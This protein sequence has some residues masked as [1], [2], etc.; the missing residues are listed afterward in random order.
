MVEDDSQAGLDHVDGH[1]APVEV[2]SPYANHATVDSHYYSQI[3]MV[4]TI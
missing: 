2:I 3:T 4:R 1:R